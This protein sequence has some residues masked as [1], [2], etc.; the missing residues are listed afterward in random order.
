MR[1]D[2]SGYLKTILHAPD[3]RIR[4]SLDHIEIG[5]NEFE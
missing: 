1:Y 2:Y 5:A 4:D 3:S